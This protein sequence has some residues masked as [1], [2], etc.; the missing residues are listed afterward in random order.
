MFARLFVGGMLIA[1]ALCCDRRT[2]SDVTFAADPPSGGA[3]NPDAPNK[4]VPP[5]L[6]KRLAAAERLY[7]SGLTK[8]SD[9]DPGAGYWEFKECVAFFSGYARCHRGLGAAAA[10]KARHAPRLRREAVEAFQRYLRL[11]PSADD[12]ASILR[13]I[14]ELESGVRH[15]ENMAS[16]S[17]MSAQVWVDPEV[18]YGPPPSRE[19]D[20]ADQEPTQQTVAHRV[21]REAIAI[22]RDLRTSGSRA[23]AVAYLEEFF[24]HVPVGVD[25]A[26]Q[27]ELWCA[28][29][30]AYASTGN[31][32]LSLQAFT[33]GIEQYPYL[34]DCHYFMCRELGPS[35]D[36][37][38]ACERYLTVDPKGRFSSD[39]KRRAS[40]APPVQPKH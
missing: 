9:D 38:R 31:R 24:E 7:E 20:D 15:R 40:E 8:S 21:A 16:S 19:S 6:E 4:L 39:A 18:Q 17:V 28:L 30:L 5:L 22:A 35:A 14:A 11:E 23:A 10:H 1:L 12:R 26:L 37:R 3:G 13:T 25:P 27:S 34:G 36:G 29:G 32:E 33:V 2:G